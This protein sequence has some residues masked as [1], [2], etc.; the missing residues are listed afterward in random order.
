[1]QDDKTNYLSDED[2]QSLIQSVE[3]EGMLHAPQYM[4]ESILNQIQTEERVSDISS[5]RSNNVQLI[6]Y[7]LKVGVAMAA[8]IALIVLVPVREFGSYSDEDTR[9]ERA[10]Y[11]EWL[12][13]Q[14]GS[15][16]A[17]YEENR[18]KEK[19]KYLEERKSMYDTTN[20]ISSNLLNKVNKIFGVED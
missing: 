7:T 18:E 1:M 5:H 13:Y 14:S 20:E 10:R 11:E 19:S 2:L 9:Y 12:D 8:A 6:T 15:D 4:K 16:K 3:Q 17:E